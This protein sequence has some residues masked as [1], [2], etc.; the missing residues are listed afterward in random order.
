MA[1]SPELKEASRRFASLALAKLEQQGILNVRQREQ[2]R[3]SLATSGEELDWADLESD[4]VVAD[5][6]KVMLRM[7]RSGAKAMAKDL[8]EELSIK[9]KETKTLAKVAASLH[10]MA[11][12]KKTEFPVIMSYDYTARDASQNYVTKTEE[13][14]LEDA[15]GVTST[16]EGMDRSAPNREKLTN[17]MIT[18]LK[19]Q[20]ARQDEMYKTLPDFVS[21]SKQLISEVM[22]TLQ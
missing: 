22:A 3:R 12:S 17:L 14:E 4:D 20:Q 9:K 6:A 21:S 16:A 10:K 1:R 11:T 7:A 18:D 19:A 8:E 15:A 13:L 5:V 2:L